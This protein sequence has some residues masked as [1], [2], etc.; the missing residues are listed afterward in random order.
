MERNALPVKKKREL[1]NLG[2]PVDEDPH[3]PEE[4]DAED[5]FP[6]GPVLEAYLVH[7]VERR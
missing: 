5:V 4:V 1:A 7:V 6:V 2:W 3:E